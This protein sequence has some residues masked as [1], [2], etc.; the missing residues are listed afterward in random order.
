MDTIY[1]VATARGRAGVSVVRVSGPA[2]Q[3]SAVLLTGRPATDRVAELRK[4][5][6]PSGQQIDTGLVI[7]FAGGKS[8]TGEETVE[9]Q[10]HGSAAVLSALLGALEELDGF[11]IAEP[12]EFSR[13]ALENERLDLTQIEGLAD[14]V[15][16]ET[17]AQRRQAL[18][19]LQ[20]GLSGQAGQWREE[21]IRALALIEVTIDFTDEE[22]PEDTYLEVGAIL[23]RLREQL[24]KEVAGAAIS[25]RI[26]DGFEVALVGAPNAGKSTLLNALAGRD[27]A[28]TSDI[29]GTT[30][31]IIEVRMDLG[32]LPVTLLDTAGLRPTEDQVERLGIDRTL[33]RAEASDVRVFLRST[34]DEEL[35][36]EP[37]AGDIIV[38]G[39]GDLTD[40]P[41]P[42]VSGLTGA[43]VD[44]LVNRLQDVLQERAANAGTAVR[45][46]QRLA[47][48]AALDYIKAAERELKDGPDRSEI[49]AENL[50]RATHALGVLIGAVDVERVLD[51]IFSSFCLGK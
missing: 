22:I 49:A 6:A 36:I 46:R 18:N 10:V 39:K 31:D 7:G 15:D 4:I 48:Q 42:S 20:G 26:R 8:F 13:R 38:Y 33:T 50:H 9:F 11:R 27:A 2:A 51:E 35:S 34:R 23:T 30:R 24:A 5:A 47:I 32:G 44:E 40:V 3:T 21:M 16:A 25:E 43:G 19:L 12:G 1:A 29:A 37:R 17:E 41:S 28:I 14:L 45:A